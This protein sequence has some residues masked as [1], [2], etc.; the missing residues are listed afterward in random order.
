MLPIKTLHI[1]FSSEGNDIKL[2]N[3]NPIII[4][5]VP[6]NGFLIVEKIFNSKFFSAA[7]QTTNELTPTIIVAQAVP[8]KPNFQLSNG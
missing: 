7:N 5:S 2:N 1:K 6:I 8:I 4:R 3:D